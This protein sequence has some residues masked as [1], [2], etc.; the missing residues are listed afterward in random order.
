M[1]RE[2]IGL[3]EGPDVHQDVEPLACGQLALVVL[4]L[5]RVAPARL[6]SGPAALAELVDP[7]LD[8]PID[9]GCRSL[10][11]LRH[12]R[13]LATRSLAVLHGPPCAPPAPKHMHHPDGHYGVRTT[14]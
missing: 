9:G 3:H 10:L 2:R 1:D 8:R 11:G 13:S 5:G 4:S 7:V 14:G 12:G 6:E